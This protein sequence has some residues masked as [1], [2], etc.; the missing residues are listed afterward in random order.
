MRDNLYNEDDHGL[1]TKKFWSHVKSNSKSS[2]LPET[3]D[4]DDTFRNKPSEKAELINNYFLN[5]FLAHQTIILIFQ[6]I[7]YLISISI[8]IECINVSLILTL[9]QNVKELFGK[10]CISS[11]TQTYF[12]QIMKL[13]ERILREELLLTSYR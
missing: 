7:K 5:N 3:M 2:R 11:F 1:I 9:W 8:K 13:L 10:P 4:L 6:T 12:T